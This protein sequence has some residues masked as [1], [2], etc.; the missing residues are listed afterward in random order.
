MNPTI[1]SHLE[2]VDRTLTYC[3]SRE[4]RTK[5]GKNVLWNIT[6]VRVQLRSSLTMLKKINQDEKTNEKEKLVAMLKRMIEQIEQR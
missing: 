5:V 3:M 1:I 6:Q 4:L 2:S